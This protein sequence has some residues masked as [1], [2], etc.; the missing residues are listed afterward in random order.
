[1]ARTRNQREL[2][3]MLEAVMIRLCSGSTLNKTQAVKLPYLVDVVATHVLGA[4]ITEGSHQAWDRGVVTSEVW[5]HLDKCEPGSSVFQVE[6]ARYSE[7]QLIQVSPGAQSTA[8]LTRE[9]EAVVDFVKEEFASMLANDLGFM[10]KVM[11]PSIKG[12]GVNR[13]ADLGP[14]AYERMS[15][16]Y[17][18]MA[19]RAASLT[20]EH[21]RR[22]SI[23]VSNIEDA[24]A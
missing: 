9:Q 8:K 18:A 20:L 2:P 4:R 16:E 23:P 14:N 6:Q 19:T 12:W 15:A 22:N 1:M 11:N 5:H 21:L 17:Q 10:T 3:P 7:E 13:P 24:I